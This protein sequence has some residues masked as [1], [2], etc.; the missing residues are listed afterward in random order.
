MNYINTEL[1]Y[2][3]LC[4][5]SGDG[6]FLTRITTKAKGTQVDSTGVLYGR[7]ATLFGHD[8]TTSVKEMVQ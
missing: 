3:V 7:E 2:H 1:C 4:E 8:M 5:D 6:P